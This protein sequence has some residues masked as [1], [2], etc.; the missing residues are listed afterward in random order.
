[1]C[2][3]QKRRGEVEI[4][5]G[6]LKAQISKLSSR[7]Q[8][9]GREFNLAKAESKFMEDA[10][11]QSELNLS[12]MVTK[13]EEQLHSL[14]I[15]KLSMKLKLTDLEEE[16][17]RMRAQLSDKRSHFGKFMDLKYENAALKNRV[18]TMHIKPPIKVRADNPETIGTQTT[19]GGVKWISSITPRSGRKGM[20]DPSLS[21]PQ[22]PRSLALK[23]QQQQR[24]SNFPPILAN[25]EEKVLSDRQLREEGVRLLADKMM[26]EGSLLTT[27][28]DFDVLSNRGIKNLTG[29]EESSSVDAERQRLL[30]LSLKKQLKTEEQISPRPPSI[31]DMRHIHDIESNVVKKG[32]TE[33][34]IKAQ[35]RPVS[36]GRPLSGRSFSS[37]RPTSSLVCKKQDEEAESKEGGGVVAGNGG[38]GADG[39]IVIPSVFGVESVSESRKNR[40]E[41]PESPEQWREL[42]KETVE[43]TSHDRGGYTVLGQPGSGTCIS[44]TDDKVRDTN[45]K[46]FSVGIP[47]MGKETRESLVIRNNKLEV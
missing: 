25:F 28:G 15:E 8:D 27:G 10:L 19:S 40:S 4:E 44:I 47:L 31:G 33:N 12:Q 39:K 30:C 32:N 35:D 5:C 6:D 18:Q 14:S 26:K 7:C 11:K 17:A 46:V 45:T 21:P 34:M 16:N 22:S 3:E 42:V 1:M 20:I 43:A 9:L 24:N 13:H 41:A 23:L 38:S 36:M 2:V 37:S 29:D